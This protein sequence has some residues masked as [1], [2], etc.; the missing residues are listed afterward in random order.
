KLET[1]REK[2]EPAYHEQ[3]KQFETE[4]A[5]F[6]DRLTK[7]PEAVQVLSEL[8][9]KIKETEQEKLKLERNWETAQQNLQQV[10]ENQTKAVMHLTNATKQLEETKTKRQDAEKQF[11]NVL[12]QSSF[13][14]EDMYQQA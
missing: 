1:E 3:S 8:E 12:A 2:H 11:T 7:I 10:K 4:K 9:K 13:E 5:V 6:Q 14:S